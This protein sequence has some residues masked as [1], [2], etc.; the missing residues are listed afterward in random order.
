MTTEV[1]VSVLADFK[2]VD[3]S[4]AVCAAHHADTEAAAAVTMMQ[5]ELP[6]W[7]LFIEFLEI[8]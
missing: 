6:R 5:K 8:I 4:S 2:G 1:A 7:N 3:R